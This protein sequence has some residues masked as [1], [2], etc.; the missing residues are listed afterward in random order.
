MTLAAFGFLH[1]TIADLLDIFLMALVIYVIFRWIR[2]SSAMSIFLVVVSLYVVR[3]VA[4]A[5]GMKMITTMMETVLDVGLLA[6]VVL[7]QPE[8]RRFL[9]TLGN[10]Y[11]GNRFI[12]G[13]LSR[14][15]GK[16]LSSETVNE[17]SEAIRSMSESRTG[18]LIVIPNEI[19]L[20]D[21]MA[22]GD[23]VDARVSRRLIMNIFFK[24]SPLHDG[25]MII[26]GGRIAAA[27]CT[28]PIT[29]K[30][31]LP[32]SYGMRHKAAIGVSEQTDADV[33]VVSEETGAVSYVRS[34]VV[35]PI[36]NINELKLILDESFSDKSEA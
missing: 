19:P 16:K 10:R 1:M 23:K 4:S 9:I 32:A 2:G 26:E 7:F 11:K 31:D 22:T 35:K 33:L 3:V 18:A 29:E 14:G 12:A 20:Y 5:L 6:L 24:N 17:V 21:I 34:G 36:A 15:S 28:L 27:R 8:I 30:M 13:L 25:A